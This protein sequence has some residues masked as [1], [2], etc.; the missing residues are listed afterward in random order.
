MHDEIQLV[1]GGSNNKGGVH[2]KQLFS[3]VPV[4]VLHLGLHY[5]HSLLVFLK[6]PSGHVGRH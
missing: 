3:R 5:V 6:V 4:H 1:R 2:D